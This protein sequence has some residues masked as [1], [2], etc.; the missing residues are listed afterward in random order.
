VNDLPADWGWQVR[1]LPT[2]AAGSVTTRPAEG[3][4][5]L[6]MDAAF[7]GSRDKDNYPILVSRPFPL[8]PGGA[9][10]LKARFR[11]SEPAAQAKFML[12]SYVANVYFWASSPSDVSLAPAWTPAEFVFRIPQEGDANYHPQ[13]KQFVV[14]VDFPEKTGSVFVDEV[15]LQEVQPLDGFAAWQQQ[16]PDKNSLVADP[17]FRNF[18]RDDFQL[19]DNSPAFGLGFER[20]PIEKIGPHAD[21]ARASWPIVEAGGA[22]EHPLTSVMK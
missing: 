11:G 7:D 19:Q 4:R 12:Q 1:P 5:C 20:I 21:P 16:G 9:Y 22:R 8:K 3:K 17:K 10:R 18:D 14:R 15:I 6:R 13:M 2:A